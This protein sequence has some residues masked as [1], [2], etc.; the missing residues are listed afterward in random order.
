MMT[1]RLRARTIAQMV[2]PMSWTT[3][4]LFEHSGQTDQMILSMAPGVGGGE[5]PHP[6]LLPAVNEGAEGGGHI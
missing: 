1:D 3:S 6:A 2:Q 4:L 5:P